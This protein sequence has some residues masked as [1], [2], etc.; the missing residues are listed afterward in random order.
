MKTKM[1]IGVIL[2]IIMLTT[3]G[4]LYSQIM[5]GS[6][7]NV[8]YTEKYG[9]KLVEI[10]TLLKNNSNKIVAKVYVTV[11][12]NDK[13]N[14]NPY[15]LSRPTKAET[16]ELNISILP[17]SE[18]RAVFSVLQP[19]EVH[20]VFSYAIIERVIYSDGSVENI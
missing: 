3:T 8:T 12:F 2:L 18:K 16:S 14:N 5:T 6:K 17:R 9:R 15:N 1:K 7:T 4:N 20:W 19:R 10:N 13:R 11:V